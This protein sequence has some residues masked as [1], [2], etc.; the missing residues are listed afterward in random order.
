MR[1]KGIKLYRPWNG[2]NAAESRLW[3]DDE[4]VLKWAESTSGRSRITTELKNLR[5]S[6]A[7]RLVE[8]IVSTSEGTSGL[9][10]GLKDAIQSDAT[11]RSRLEAL[12]HE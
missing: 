10:R 6:A 8:K 11:L 7:T 2:L 5:A 3:Q 4:T 12:I 1:A 9:L